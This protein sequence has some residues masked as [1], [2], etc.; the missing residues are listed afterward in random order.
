MCTNVPTLTCEEIITEHTFTFNINV[1]VT[2]KTLQYSLLDC[3]HNF[4]F[5]SS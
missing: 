3:L 2:D 4:D 5:S 1:N